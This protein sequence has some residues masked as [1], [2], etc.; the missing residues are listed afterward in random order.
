MSVKWP[1]KFSDSSR[2][3]DEPVISTDFYP[4]LL[5][6]AGLPM[7]DE[8]A[9]DGVSF[10]PALN[11]ESFNRGPIF[12]HFPQYSNHGMQSPGGAVRLGDFKLLEYFE[13]DTVQLFNLREDISERNDLSLTEPVIREELRRLLH[14]WREDVN[15]QMPKLNLNYDPNQY[16]HTGSQ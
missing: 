5:E 12:W 1:E 9:L 13:N 11:G 3:V 16:P 15:A 10:V 2:I 14:S 6:M 4:S 7:R 8:Q